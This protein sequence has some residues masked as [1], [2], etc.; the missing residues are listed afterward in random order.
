MIAR[1]SSGLHTVHSP[2]MLPF[3]HGAGSTLPLQ[4]P[5]LP[6]SKVPGSSL[7]INLLLKGASVGYYV[8][9]R[10]ATILWFWGSVHVCVV[11]PTIF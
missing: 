9:G 8:V 6:V 11:A 3:S 7:K 10:E 4:L 1:E 5:F 2:L